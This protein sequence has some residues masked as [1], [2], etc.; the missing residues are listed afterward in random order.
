MSVTK[1]SLPFFVRLGLGKVVNAGNTYTRKDKTYTQI[2]IAV[3]TYADG[4]VSVN[5]RHVPSDGALSEQYDRV[6]GIPLSAPDLT[7]S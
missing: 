5:A 3:R 2:L 4:F 7:W 6:T 1:T